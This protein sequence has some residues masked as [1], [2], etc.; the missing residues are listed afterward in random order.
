LGQEKTE[1]KTSKTNKSNK[2]TKKKEIKRITQGIVL[3]ILTLK[4]FPLW[5]RVAIL[6]FLKMLYLINQTLIWVES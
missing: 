6:S 2:K 3:A 5:L 4:I 1:E